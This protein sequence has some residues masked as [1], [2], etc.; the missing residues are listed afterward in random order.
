VLGK[1]VRDPALDLQ[2]LAAVLLAPRIGRS[3]TWRLTYAVLEAYVRKD[4]RR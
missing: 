1:R 4:L 3:E 2:P